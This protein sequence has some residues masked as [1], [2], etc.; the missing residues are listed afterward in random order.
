MKWTAE[1][2][3]NQTGKVAIVTGANSGIGFET[4]KALAAKGA[5]IIMACRNA[6]KAQAAITDIKKDVKDAK[7]ELIQLDL[8]DLESVK[9][10]A[11]N[12]KAKY[13]QLDILINNAGI[14]MPP[15][16]KTKDGFEVQFG[17]NHLGHF[18]LTAELMD[19]IRKTNAA[20]VVNVSSSAHRMGTNTINFDDLNAEKEYKPATSYAQ[21][22]LANLLFTR[23]LNMYFQAANT[24]AM[25]S[26]AHPGWTSTNLQEYSRMFK[27]LNPFF[28]QKPP[29]GALPTL[30]AAVADLKANDYAGP[31]G[32]MEMRGSPK[33]VDMSDAAKDDALAKRLWDVSEELTGISYEAGRVAA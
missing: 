20:R 9:A 16:T 12:F 3:P 31:S 5:T 17:A 7:L 14:M 11:V 1:N 6:S 10:F 32:F 13:D 15:Y 23:Q 19:V 22:K 30:Y 29:M 33:L 18:A 8:A 27:M 26:S 4:A 2:I 24:D 28:S 21:S 25:A